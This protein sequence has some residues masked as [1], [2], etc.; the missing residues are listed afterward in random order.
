MDTAHSFSDCFEK[1]DYIALEKGHLND[2]LT[3]SVW[4]GILGRSCLL[5]HCFIFFSHRIS[6]KV[7]FIF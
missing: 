7:L 3:L 1:C 5:I 4:R 2:L 6:L